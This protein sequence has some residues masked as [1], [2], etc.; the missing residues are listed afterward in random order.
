MGPC[1][2]G[3]G[4]GGGAARVPWSKGNGGEITSVPLVVSSPLI[5]RDRSQGQ[6]GYFQIIGD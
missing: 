2:V 3:A 6:V 4:G 1:L 5:F